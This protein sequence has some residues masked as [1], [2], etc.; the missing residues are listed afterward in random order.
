MWKKIYKSNPPKIMERNDLQESRRARNAYLLFERDAWRNVHV[1][2]PDWEEWYGLADE[3]RQYY[4]QLAVQDVKTYA[5]KMREYKLFKI[6]RA[7][8]MHMSQGRAFFGKKQ[9][10]REKQQVNDAEE[11]L[12][13]AVEPGG[14]AAERDQK[15]RDENLERRSSNE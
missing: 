1:E 14:V 3:Q 6:W 10:R 11:L 4:L 13:K 12:R 8:C 2:H 5:A 15:I 9:Q 7:L